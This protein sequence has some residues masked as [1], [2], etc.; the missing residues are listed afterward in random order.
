MKD[1][2]NRFTMKSQPIQEN[3]DVVIVGSVPS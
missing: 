1:Y 2:F 3:Y